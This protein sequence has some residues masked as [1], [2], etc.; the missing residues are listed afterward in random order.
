MS[1]LLAVIG[2]D[3]RYLEL[4]KQMQILPDTDIVLAGYDTLEQGFI[5]QKQV[6]FDDIESDQLDVVILPITGTDEKG[7]VETVF[8]DKHIQLTREWFH[9]LKD[10][11]VI[12]T[13]ITNDYLTNAAAEADLTLIPLL[14]RDD[15]AIYNSIPTAEGAIMMAIEHTDYTIHSSRIMVT[16]FGRVGHTV[17]NKLSALGANVSVSS[18]STKELARIIEMG[19]TPVPLEQLGEHMDRCDL[20]IN[21]IPA[22]VITKEIIQ[23]LPPHG[24]IIDLASKPGGTDFDFAKKR[25]IRAILA[26]SLP[27]IVAPKTSGKILADVMKQILKGESGK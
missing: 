3:A 2:G 16:G 15:V 17:A 20:V 26:K 10:S 12:F 11:A 22:P 7:N 23:Q 9:Q 5:G 13:G 25:G 6:D 8:S 14:N 27:N 21:T 19:L 1:R 18:Q 24:I 4:I